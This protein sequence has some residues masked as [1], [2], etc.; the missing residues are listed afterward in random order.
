MGIAT[1]SQIG[2]YEVL[3]LIGEGGMGKVYL[4]RDIRLGRTVA[5]K[6]LPVEIASDPKRI[7]RFVQEAR[8]ASALNHPNILTI[9]EIEQTG[10]AHY[11]AT[12]FIEGVTLRDHL[13]RTKLSISETLDIAAQI[14]SAI[15]AAHEVG[16]VHRDLK[17]ENIMVRPDGLIKILDF[18]VAKV[19]TIEPTDE[20]DADAD[21]LAFFNTQPGLLIGTVRYMS[22][23]QA[24]G[25]TVDSRSDIWSLAIVLYE[26]LTKELP[27]SGPTNADTIAALIKNP[28]PLI[29]DYRT[30]APPEL[31]QVIAKALEKKPNK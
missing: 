18:G 27:F 21:T 15:A 24:R 6:I 13:S 31:Q 8:A 11:I 17:P 12:E 9:Y 26:M 10:D 22:P 30:D 4:A 25:A 28:T 29:S 20:V 5:L 19:P 1:G 16:V 3:S 2:R 23:E 14:A 7:Y